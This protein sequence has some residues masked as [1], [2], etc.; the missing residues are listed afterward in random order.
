[1]W[2]ETTAPFR[3][4]DEPQADATPHPTG[5]PDGYDPPY[6]APVD[7]TVAAF[8][9]P[10]DPWLAADATVTLGN[11][12]DAYADLAGSNGFG[13]GDLHA[14]ITAAGEL[15]RTYDTAADP[16][17]SVDQIMAAVTQLFYVVNWLHDYWYDSGFDETAGNAQ[18]DNYGRGGVAGDVL[19]AEAQDQGGTNNAN[20]SPGVDGMSPRM[21]MYVFD[22]PSGSTVRRDGTIDNLIVAHEW[23][24]YLHLRLVSCGSQ[25]CGAMSEGWADFNAMFLAVRAGD[26]LDGTYAVSS[27][28]TRAFTDDAAYFG[29]RRYPY[30][31]DVTKNALTFR[32][33]VNGEPL[34]ADVPANLIYSADNFEVHNAGEVWGSMLWEGLVAMLRQSEGATPRYTFEEARRRYADYLVAGMKAAPTEPTFTEQRDAILAAAAASDPDDFV[35]L[36]AAFARRGFGSGAISPPTTT[37]TGAPVTESFAVTGALGFDGATVA[38][39]A[40]ACDGDGL[41]DVGETA[42]IH[43][44]LINTGPAPLAAPTVT[45][46]SATPGAF[47]PDGGGAT[48]AGPIAPFA[49]A[50]APVK[51][52]LE[53]SAAAPTLLALDVTL[54]DP[55]AALA[56]VSARLQV[57]V[58]L[59]VTP[60]ASAVDDVESPAPLW[61]ATGSWRRE[62]SAAGSHTWYAVGVATAGDHAL[63]SPPLTI[64]GGFA[65]SFQHRYQLEASDG[66][67]W[68]GVVLEVSTDG[69]ATWV[70]AATLAAT[71]YDGTIAGVSGNPIGG[72]TAWAGTSAGYPAFASRTI[73][74]GTALDGQTVRLRFRLGTDAAVGSFGFELDDVAVTGAGTPFAATVVEPSPCLPGTRPVADAGPDL[75]VV[76]GDAVTLDGSGSSDPDGGALTY[77]WAQ[78]AGP[79][80]TL[81]RAT[82][83]SAS[84]IAPSVAEV[85]TVRVGL[86]VRDPDTRVSLADEAAVVIHPAFPPDGSVVEPADAGPTGATTDTAGCGCT[87]TPPTTALLLALLALPLLPRRRRRPGP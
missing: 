21:Q 66:A 71:G 24:H 44:G 13:T 18:A 80:V 79:A 28:V 47:F 73:D 31:T 49:T 78:V 37:E 27:Y 51:V 30:S 41:L 70:D 69:G 84:F 62:A 59:D 32:H 57:D 12:V 8:N 25:V 11:N 72:R 77:D 81:E 48:F 17:S 61:T 76:S 60:G 87:S 22:A 14:T 50:T 68:D 46:T 54:H 3:P 45:V 10:A 6:V 86:I 82:T 38:E 5:V 2:A 19:L 83:T 35:L 39:D 63:V 43:V 9:A 75:D 53:E 67:L 7:V 36:A 1:V 55:G 58:N 4:L 15:R 34:P 26:A 56:E 23:G 20:M 65:L 42:T 74:F 52:R 40:G 64:S 29:I 33:V 16:Q 85:T